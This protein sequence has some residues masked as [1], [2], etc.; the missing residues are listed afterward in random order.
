MG[1]AEELKQAVGKDIGAFCKNGF[2]G[3]EINHCA[4]FAS[5]MCGMTFSYHC[6]NQVG[7]THSPGNLRVNEVFAQC[8]KVGHWKD[9]DLKRSQLIFV[10]HAANVNLATKTMVAAP[11]KH[12]GVLHDG[13][14]YHYSN[15]ADKVVA[16]NVAGFKA[17][18]D[19]AYG[20][21]QGYFFG[22]IPGENL[23]LNVKAVTENISAEK[24][25][26]LPD[27]VNGVW[28]AKLVGENQPFL[29]GR[30]TRDPAKGYYGLYQKP[31]EYYG[32]QF[33]AKDYLAEIGQWAVFLE[34]TGA[35]ESLNYFNL[36]N[37]Y[38]RAKFTFGFYQLAAHTPRDNLILLFRILAGLSAFQSYFPELELRG[39][40]LFRV[41]ADGSAT[42]LEQ[43]FKASNGEMQLMLFMNYLNPTRD[44]IE[45]QEAL[46][47]ARLIHWSNT[48]PDMR[49]AQVQVAA[50]ILQRKFDK[51][52]GPKLK[53]DGESDTVCAIV[54]DIRHQG[55]ANNKA[56]LGCLAA[57]DK[58]EAL[59]TINDAKFPGRNKRLRAQVEAAAKAGRLGKMRYIAATN[60]FAPIK[61]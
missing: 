25:F 23:L 45:R 55:R 8:P 22:W 48:D 21:G 1:L 40:R 24:K 39:G 19:N 51:D 14:V 11:K 16:E 30:E 35:C 37:T 28:T 41:D 9:A 13:L 44:E 43:E 58:I 38:D 20:P 2:T 5:H 54:S 4:H 27:P 53:L 46:Q 10:T 26:D 52:Y 47:A 7:G 32:P 61:P 60:D 12:I 56:I 50:Q 49:R 6:K 34:V 33:Q 59:L 57:S 17:R 29:V 15:T 3:A 36:I 42:D 31:S 18:F